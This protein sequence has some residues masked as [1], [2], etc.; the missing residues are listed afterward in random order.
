[1]RPLLV[2]GLPEPKSTVSVNVP[3]TATRPL[4]SIATVW[5]MSSPGPPSAL[6][7][8]KRPSRSNTATNASRSPAADTGPAPKSTSPEK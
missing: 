7:H 8:S 6:A 1:M 2:N 4:L 3:A 5:P